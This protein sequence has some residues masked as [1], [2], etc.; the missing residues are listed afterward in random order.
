MKTPIAR[1][2]SYRCA[3]SRSPDICSICLRASRSEED[4]EIDFKLVSNEDI[5]K[6]YPFEFEYHIRF[7]LVDTKINMSVAVTNHD[8]KDL[9][10][11]LGG[12][13]G[14]NIPLE[15]GEFTDYY[16]EFT[17][18]SEPQGIYMSDTCYTTNKS[19]D[20][21]VKDNKLALKHNLFDRDALLVEGLKD[22][23]AIKN[24][25]DNR[26]VIVEIPSEMKYV[27]IWHAPK[28][29]APYVCVEP[30]TSVPAYD[31][32]VDDLETKR[33]MFIIKKDKTHTLDWS[34]T[35]K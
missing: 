11:A 13:P 23:I 7:K 22:K 16:L 1:N 2:F 32:I 3:H 31:G 33:D 14:F 18:N 6:S 12:H 15:K 26:E 29:E 4:S 27:G 24:T 10:F 8:N 19:F 5:Y 34:I 21:P 30:W 9:F 25:V 20:I 17:D 28:T 35:V